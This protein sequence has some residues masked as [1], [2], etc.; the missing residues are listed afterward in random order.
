MGAE[1]VPTFEPILTIVQTTDFSSISFLSM[2]NVTS[3]RLSSFF[4]SSA[5]PSPDMTSI[6]CVMVY[7]VPV[8]GSSIGTATGST[9]VFTF[10]S[11]V[12]KFCFEEKI[13]SSLPEYLTSSGI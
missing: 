6:S 9:V 13:L 4:E 3:A 10:T 7:W 8:H 2:L 12:H 5:F 11:K 1:S